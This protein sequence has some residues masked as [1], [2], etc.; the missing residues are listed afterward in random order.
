MSARDC[1]YTSWIDDD[2][3]AGVTERGV[4]CV[5]EKSIGQNGA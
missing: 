2:V 4:G 3:I 1:L 5:A